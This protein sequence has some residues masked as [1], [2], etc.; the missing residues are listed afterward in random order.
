[1]KQIVR[2]I[3]RIIRDEIGKV[4]ILDLILLTVGGLIMAPMLGLMSTGLLAGQV[5]EKKMG[6]LYAADA[7]VEYAIWHLE[8][9]GDPND[10]PEFSLN[11]KN[12]TIQIDVEW[13]DECY[14]PAVYE[15]TS[16]ATG[17]DNSGTTIL[18]RVTGIFVYIEDGW[19]HSGEMVE[20]DVYAEGDL[21]ID[22][23]AQITGN[24][25]VVGNLIMNE[26]S[27]V[28]GVVCVGGDVTF[29]EG[30]HVDS[31]I[32]I[33]GNLLM[34][35]GST[36]SSINGT[37][38]VRGTVQMQGASTLSQDLW[39]GGDSVEIDANALAMEDVHVTAAEVVSAKPGVILGDIYEDYYDDWGCPLEFSEPEILVWVIV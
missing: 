7:G 12:V 3:R 10:V 33:G 16:T 9:G 27:L 20:G 32:F 30:A 28:G 1:M 37:A 26:S 6:E 2:R 11:S 13:P 24:T 29:N 21:L 19:L 14:E 4:L 8:Q 39:A 22:N 34:Q 15:I 25:I 38:Y 5:S 18:A 35:G 17:A 36:G 31:D 23:D